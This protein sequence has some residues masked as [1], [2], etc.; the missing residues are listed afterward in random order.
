MDRSRAGAARRCKDRKIHPSLKSVRNSDLL[1]TAFAARRLLLIRR[2][3]G[4]VILVG[5]ETAP[6]LQRVL[7]Y[8]ERNR[9]PYRWAGPAEQAQGQG[10]QTSTDSTG[11]LVV[12][13]GQLRSAPAPTRVSAAWFAGTAWSPSRRSSSSAVAA[14]SSRR[15]RAALGFHA[16]LARNPSTPPNATIIA[17]MPRFHTRIMIVASNA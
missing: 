4:T 1:L 14:G 2:Q 5:S 13:G 7:Q 12:V 3:Q 8:A 6:T 9:I 17:A 10:I 15:S 16:G 11:A